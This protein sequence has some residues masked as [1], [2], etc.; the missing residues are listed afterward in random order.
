LAGRTP[1]FADIDPEFVAAD[2]FPVTLPLAVKPY[3][4][5]VAEGE[6]GYHH[7][8]RLFFELMG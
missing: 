1:Y 3:R 2:R 7:H 4:S 6:A 5:H 8:E